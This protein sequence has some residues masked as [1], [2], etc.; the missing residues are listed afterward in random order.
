MRVCIGLPGPLQAQYR[1]SRHDHVLHA[2][3][4]LAVP[5]YSLWEYT[6]LQTL[7]ETLLDTQSGTSNING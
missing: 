4:I 3:Q 2:S 6:F 5:I 1:R 7:V